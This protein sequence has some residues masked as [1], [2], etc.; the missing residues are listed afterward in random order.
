MSL[1]P[2]PTSNKG[3]SPTGI[4]PVSAAYAEAL[5]VISDDRMRMAC[6]LVLAEPPP[7]TTP[8]VAYDKLLEYY[9][10][11]QKAVATITKEAPS[12]VFMPPPA[13]PLP[14]NPTRTGT[15]GIGRMHAKPVKT[16]TAAALH[17][18]HRQRFMNRGGGTTA[19]AGVDRRAA[20]MQQQHKQ[21]SDGSLGS[22]REGATAAA[23]L[24][25]TI[26]APPSKKLRLATG[27]RVTGTVTSAAAATKDMNPPPEARQFLAKL[28]KE[29]ARTS[30]PSFVSSK[31]VTLKKSHNKSE[32]LFHKQSA[33][34]DRKRKA[35]D[36]DEQEEQQDNDEDHEEEDEHQDDDDGSKES[37]SSKKKDSPPLRARPKRA[38]SESS[39]QGLPEESSNRRVQPRRSA[40]NS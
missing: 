11:C 35:L 20:M 27:P 12:E 15:G 36:Q 40:R 19:P 6:R 1:A 16:G 18:H 38:A 7:L 37:L 9:K 8:T 29:S 4:A 23:G 30:T 14:A 22:A 21:N 17:H 26:K 2:R 5:Q 13:I 24:S 32:K 28:N 25:G 10:E 34:F 33:L 39:Q 3:P 31:D